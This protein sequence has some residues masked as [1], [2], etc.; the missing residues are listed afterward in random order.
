[1]SL[2]MYLGSN[3]KVTNRKRKKKLEKPNNIVTVLS[4]FITVTNI[5]ITVFDSP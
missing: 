4:L 5:F 3:G 2:M 1:M